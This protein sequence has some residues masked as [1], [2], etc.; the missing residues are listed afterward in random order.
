M[1]FSNTPDD[2]SMLNLPLSNTGSKPGASNLPIHINNIL[3]AQNSATEVS[4][5]LL[6]PDPV[7]E[8]AVNGYVHSKY[9]SKLRHW[10]RF[11]Y[12]KAFFYNHSSC[13]DTTYNIY[14]YILQN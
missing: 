9:T 13:T 1:S 5:W 10:L 12:C 3:H 6:I 2:I 8:S 14:M 11:R 7:R 4:M